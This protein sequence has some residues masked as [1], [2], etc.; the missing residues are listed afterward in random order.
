MD[1]D[2]RHCGQSPS[3]P[4]DTVANCERARPTQVTKRMIG[5][6]ALPACLHTT[7]Q[8][9][10]G[11]IY[12]CHTPSSVA[13]THTLVQS[14]W[15]RPLP[16][17]TLNLLSYHKEGRGTVLICQSQESDDDGCRWAQ[18]GES[19]GS[20]KGSG[21]ATVRHWPPWSFSLRV[22]ALSNL[23]CF[24][25]KAQLTGN[26]PIRQKPAWKSAWD[27]FMSRAV[28]TFDSNFLT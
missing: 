2:Q 6:V 13:P 14:K 16:L 22:W 19:G 11:H 8:R 26:K 23:S 3:F 21:D 12:H 10:T 27:S 24:S 18:T 7:P 17:G 20:E 5:T 25:E 4:E 15:F 1:V 9:H 28:N